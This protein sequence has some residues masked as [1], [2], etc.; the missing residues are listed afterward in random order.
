MRARLRARTEQDQQRV[1][2]IAVA[3]VQSRTGL[4]QPLEHGA[5][6]CGVAATERMLRERLQRRHARIVRRIRVGA[7]FE[8]RLHRMRSAERGGKDQRSA[9]A[10]NRK[11]DCHAMAEQGAH[12]GFTARGDGCGEA[13]HARA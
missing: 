3:R 10:G 4:R 8:Q 7:R 9:T 13:V 1:L 2:S 11:V 12:D 6:V 5:C